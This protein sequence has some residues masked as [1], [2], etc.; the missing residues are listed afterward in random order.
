MCVMTPASLRTL[1]L[2]FALLLFITCGSQDLKGQ[3]KEDLTIAKEKQEHAETLRLAGSSRAADR[4]LA[5]RR[6]CIWDK[7]YELLWKLMNDTDPTVRLNA[8]DGISNGACKV[9]VNLT[10]ELARKMVPMLEKEVTPEHIDAAFKT[11]QIRDEAASL[12]VCSTLALDFIFAELP[13]LKTPRADG[14]RWQDVSLHPLMVKLAAARRETSDFLDRRY[15]EMLQRIEDAGLLMME[16]EALGETL[17]DEKLPSARLLTTVETLWRAHP[18]LGENKPLYLML[19]VQLSPR[20]QSLRPR[21]LSPMPEGPDKAWAAD[22]L[23]HIATDIQ[24]AREKF[25]PQPG[26]TAGK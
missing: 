9:A 3:S 21:I 5:I 16:L 10:P 23:D 4:N 22:F 8:I 7:D 17:D 12:V 26:G 25:K 11:G 18:L 1:N 13:E 20:L 15:L 2:P 14:A 24:T 19:L 6:L